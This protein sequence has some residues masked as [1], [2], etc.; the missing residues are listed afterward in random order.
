MNKDNSLGLN[1]LLSEY[2]KQFITLLS[3]V[4]ILFTTLMLFVN[5]TSKE[6]SLISEADNKV[7][8]VE[9]DDSSKI[10][11][12]G[13]EL[14]LRWGIKRN[15]P[16]KLPDADP[17]VSQLFSK[18]NASY[19]GDT[20]KKTIYLSF[21]EGYENGYTGQILDVLK[22]QKVQAAFFITGPYLN[23]E[24][25]LVRRMVEE[26]HIVGNHTVNHLSMPLQTDSK[27][28][29]ELTELDSKYFEMFNRNM[30]F[31][32]PPKGEYSERLLNLTD[33]MGYCTLFWSFA[34]DDWKTNVI[35]GKDYVINKILD[36]AHNGMVILLHAVSKDNAEALQ[37]I[38]VKLRNAGYEFGSCEDLYK[39]TYGG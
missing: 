31:L 27:I 28:M 5:S 9:Y 26:G 14:M 10:V 1:A 39:K 32:R 2:K 38:I 17:G 20:T 13:K 37:D 15:G 19:I 23:T 11:L 36:N 35:R 8:I 6:L 29:S 4:V 22:K 34:Y 30:T 25:D 18:H 24:V 12:N 7:S 33:K 21:D 3:I 16:G